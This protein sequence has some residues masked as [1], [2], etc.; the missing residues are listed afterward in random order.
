MSFVN[1]T[2]HD[3]TIVGYGTIPKSGIVVRVSTTS[4]VVESFEG[5]DIMSTTFGDIENLPSPVN[6]TRYIVSRIVKGACP[7]RSDCLVPGDLVRDPSGVI[8]GCRGLSL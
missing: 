6:G 4:T 2:P 3:I 5:V 8:L 1:L 7:S